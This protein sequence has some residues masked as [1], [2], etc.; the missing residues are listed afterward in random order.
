MGKCEVILMI[1]SSIISYFARF[2]IA[3]AL[4]ASCTSVYPHFFKIE[5][6]SNDKQDLLLV[7]DFHRSTTDENKCPL[8]QRQEIA[9]FAR[10][11]GAGVIVEDGMIYG[12][13]LVRS[14]SVHMQQGVF[15]KCTLDQKA[16]EIPI[17]GLHSLCKLDGVDSINVE[18]RFSQCRPLNVYHAFFNNKKEQILNNFKD[19]QVFE[20]YYTSTINT[21]IENIE[22]PLAPI[23][24]QFKT[25]SCI[26]HEYLQQK[27]IPVVNNI[28]GLIKKVAPQW[29]SSAMSYP[30]KIE[31]M[32][33]NYTL[34]FLDM[35]I[36]HT[37]SLFKDKKIILICAGNRHIDNIKSVLPQFGFSC[38][39]SCGND[40]ILS[41]GIKYIEPKA[42]QIHQTLS[43]LMPESNLL[44]PYYL[45]YNPFFNVTIPF[46]NI[47]YA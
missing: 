45:Y 39:E 13:A 3:T 9:D 27:N 32:L 38:V 20:H 10:K 33:T 15:P 12:D 31:I 42:I 22:K 44:K 47:F 4:L 37:M 26:L 43:Q 29:N 25:S 21:L 40:L 8:Q 23:L 28:D 19:G 16:I 36:V 18:F 6:W 11:S 46:W 41:N 2:A 1:F 34:A 30:N 14:P 35:E 17:H 5:K 7:S 24:E